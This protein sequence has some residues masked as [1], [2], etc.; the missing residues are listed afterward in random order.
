MAMDRR[1]LARFVRFQNLANGYTNA[2][3]DMRTIK[4]NPTTGAIQDVYLFKSDRDGSAAINGSSIQLQLPVELNRQYLRA[5]HTSSSH[6]TLE[7][8]LHPVDA[9]AGRVKYSGDKETTGDI[10]LVRYRS[11]IR[12]W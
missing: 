3:V 1:K 12:R 5:H 11:D 6:I 10:I 4:Y 7:A 9:F 2:R 8:E